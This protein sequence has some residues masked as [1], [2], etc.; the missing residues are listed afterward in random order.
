MVSEHG[1]VLADYGSCVQILMCVDTAYYGWNIG[2]YNCHVASFGSSDAKRAA[3]I[4]SESD[5]TVK[6]R[7]WPGSHQVTKSVEVGTSADCPRVADKSG[8]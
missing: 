3:P 2:C 7:L 1:S 8:E 5:T 6:G 4:S